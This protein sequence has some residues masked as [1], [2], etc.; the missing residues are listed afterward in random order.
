M[1]LLAEQKS[2]PTYKEVGN[3]SEDDIIKR[4]IEFCD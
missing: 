1:T 4:R 3:E 2:T